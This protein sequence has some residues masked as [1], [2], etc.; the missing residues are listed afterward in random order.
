MCRRYLG[1]QLYS[2]GDSSIC[3]ACV[4]QSTRRGGA[5]AYKALRDTMEE[6]VIDGGDDQ[7]LEFLIHSND[8]TIQ[9]ILQDVI[10]IH[11]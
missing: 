1:T 6:H 7:I 10:D 11:K 4:K 8:E 9:R 3:N 2:D 5:T